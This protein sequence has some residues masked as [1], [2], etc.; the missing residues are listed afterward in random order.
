[1][2]YIILFSHLEYQAGSVGRI[3]V[4]RRNW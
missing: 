2:S 3:W 4:T 1:L